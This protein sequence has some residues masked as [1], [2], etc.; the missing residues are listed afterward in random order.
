MGDNQVRSWD[1]FHRH[2]AICMLRPNQLM[3]EMCAYRSGLELV[4]ALDIRSVIAFKLPG[5]DEIFDDMI[6]DF[7]KKKSMIN[8]P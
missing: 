3:E 7:F 1:G 6:R 5:S 8:I 2:L 4:T